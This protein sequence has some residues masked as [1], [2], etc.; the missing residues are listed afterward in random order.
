[1]SEPKRVQFDGV[2]VRFGE[3]GIKSPPVRRQ[4]LERL[5]LNLL[6]Q[7]VR[8][9]VEGDVRLQSS[10][11]WMQGPDVAAL[12]SVATRTFGVVSASPCIRAGATMDAIGAVAVPLALSRPWTS[13]AVRANREGTHAFTSQDIGIQ[14]G[15]A[16]HQAATR[17]GRTPKVDLGKP[18]VEV[19]VDVRGSEAFVFLD[20]LAGPGGIPAGSQ[21]LV[22]CVLGRDDDLIAAWLMMR[23][24]CA[25]LPFLVGDGP[26]QEALA[27]MQPWGLAP[28]DTA[29]DAGEA[30]SKAHAQGALALVD[31][32]GLDT[33]TTPWPHL[34]PLAGLQ[35]SWLVQLRKRVLGDAA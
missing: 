12:A 10:R 26:S 8:A 6:D 20:H 34:A 21:G 32:R 14:V 5:R 22:G 7:M 17:A 25:V 23:R 4:M 28:A 31:G 35:P 9:G 2:L 29:R 1:M 15:S 16:I 33:A 19:H 3:I 13:F 30:W 27:A 18:D 24:G 11:L